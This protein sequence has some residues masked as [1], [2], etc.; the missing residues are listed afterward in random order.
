MLV[1]EVGRHNGQRMKT[2]F[3]KAQDVTDITCQNTYGLFL[4]FKLI[5]QN[6]KVY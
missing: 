3:Y 6:L 4:M 5:L 1:Q 2:A